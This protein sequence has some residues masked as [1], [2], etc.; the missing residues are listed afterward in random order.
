MYEKQITGKP[1]FPSLFLFSL[2]SV[3]AIQVSRERRHVLNRYNP[4]SLTITLTRRGEKGKSSLQYTSTY[5]TKM[6]GGETTNL[7]CLLSNF[8]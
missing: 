4:S 5:I 2:L 8:A 7:E 1:F 3:R 6:E